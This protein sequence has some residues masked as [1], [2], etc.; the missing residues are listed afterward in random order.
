MSMFSHWIREKFRNEIDFN[1]KTANLCE[2]RVD[3]KFH[4]DHNRNGIV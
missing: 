1:L 3:N 4:C 2:T